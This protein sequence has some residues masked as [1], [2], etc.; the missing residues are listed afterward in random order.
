MLA[1]AEFW[2]FIAFLLFIGVFG[3]KAFGFLNQSLDTYRQKITQDL[4]VAQNL[5]DEAL[6]LLGSYKKKHED[7]IKQ[8]EEIMSYAE[9]EALEFKQSSEQEFER[10]VA[11]KEK[12]LLERIAIKNEEAKLKL[13]KEAINEAIS[14]VEHVLSKDTAQKKKINNSALKEVLKNI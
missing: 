3:K 7:A 2:V 13:R 11:Q 12:A 10:F 4:E 5:H 6:S 1:T 9:K 8:A 14:I